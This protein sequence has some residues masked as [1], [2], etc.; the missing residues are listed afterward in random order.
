MQGTIA[1]FNQPAN[2]I[3]GPVGTITE[4]GPNWKSVRATKAKEAQKILA[5][6]VAG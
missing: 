1:R 2:I 4:A 6:L 5:A 3:Q